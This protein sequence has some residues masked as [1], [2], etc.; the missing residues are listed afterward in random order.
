MQPIR[1]LSNWL[2]LNASSE[3]YLFTLSDMRALFPEL[4]SL[5]FKTLLSRVG[6]SEHLKRLCRSLYYYKPANTSGLILF[7]AAASLRAHEFNYISLETALSDAGVI[8]QIPINRITIMSSGRSNIVSC[9]SYGTIEFVHTSQKP[10]T[11]MEQLVYDAR[12]RLWRALVPQALRD[13]RVTHRNCDLIDWDAV[14][15]FV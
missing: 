10:D 2:S 6:K 11:V 14:H 4:S 13:M 5:A 15:E 8:S 1:I 12:C 3:H 9:G 7:H